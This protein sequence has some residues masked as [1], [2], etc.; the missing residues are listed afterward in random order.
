M[1]AKANLSACSTSSWCGLPIRLPSLRTTDG[2]LLQLNI[3]SS[4]NYGRAI[5]GSQ[6][7][8]CIDKRQ[9]GIALWGNCTGTGLE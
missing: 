4:P 6:R 7:K 1:L 9:I 5:N 2:V 8:H 3:C